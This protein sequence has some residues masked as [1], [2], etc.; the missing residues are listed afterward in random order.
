MQF[1]T[2][3]CTKH[4]TTQYT[5]KLICNTIY[6][7]CVSLSWVCLEFV[8]VCVWGCVK[9]LCSVWVCLEF[10]WVCACRCVILCVIMYTAHTCIHTS[11]I[12]E[13]TTQQANK[14]LTFFLLL[15][16]ACM[17]LNDRGNKCTVDVANT[18]KSAKLADSLHFP[19]WGVFPSKRSW[20]M[21]ITLF[22]LFISLLCAGMFLVLSVKKYN[23]LW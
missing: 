5:C 3:V 17:L 22:L 20:I 12:Y 19:Q 4:M 9:S 1:I 21:T 23:F 6:V 8:R 15:L 18:I 10:V 13:H 7:Q 14:T 2:Y 16:A 11:Q